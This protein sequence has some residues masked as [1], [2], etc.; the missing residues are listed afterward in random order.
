MPITGG[1]ALGTICTFAYCHAASSSYGVR[2]RLSQCR[3]EVIG[4]RGELGRRNHGLKA[5]Y[6]HCHQNREYRHRDHQF[7][8]GQAACAMSRLEKR[9]IVHRAGCVVWPVDAITYANGSFWR[10]VLLSGL[11]RVTNGQWRVATILG[12]CAKACVGW[13]GCGCLRGWQTHCKSESAIYL[14]T[15]ETVH[16][17][18]V[19]QTPMQ[20]PVGAETESLVDS[21][22]MRDYRLTSSTSV[23]NSSISSKLR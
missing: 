4:S 23:L 15:V 3:H 18:D 19:T 9:W 12:S 5:R 22:A 21:P 10:C 7:D 2:A 11:W 13:E 17:A 16:H 20:L 1:N 6:G 8:Q 14:E